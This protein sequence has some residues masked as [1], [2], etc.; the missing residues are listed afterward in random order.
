MTS[1]CPFDEPDTHEFSTGKLLLLIGKVPR[2]V[3]DYNVVDL[4]QLQKL[5]V[6]TSDHVFRYEFE[7][8]L[9]EL[10]ESRIDIL[11]KKYITELKMRDYISQYNTE[12]GVTKSTRF[13]YLL[14]AWLQNGCFRFYSKDKCEL[15]FDEDLEVSVKL[16]D[17]FAVW[18]IFFTLLVVSVLL[19]V[20]D[21]KINFE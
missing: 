21:C 17:L 7:K 6:A 5:F 11:L 19:L 14:S 9:A 1:T 12:N 10:S 3:L 4:F 18:I 2:K 16:L 15:N 8:I 20:Y 13:G